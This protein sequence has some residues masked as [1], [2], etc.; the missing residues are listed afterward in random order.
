LTTFRPVPRVRSYRAAKIKTWP[1]RALQEGVI[2][3]YAHLLA[4]WMLIGF[5]HC[6]MNAD[7]TSISGECQFA[8]AGR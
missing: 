2:A 7:N 4:R 3:R 1:Y 8:I 5:I 6:V